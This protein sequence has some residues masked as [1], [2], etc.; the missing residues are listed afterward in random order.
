MEK[1]ILKRC[2]TNNLQPGYGKEVPVCSCS[3]VMA[4][5][6]VEEDKVLKPLIL[7]V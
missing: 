6:G 5:K 1:R 4:S 2:S 3:L 7:Q